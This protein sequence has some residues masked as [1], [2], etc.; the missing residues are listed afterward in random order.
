[1]FPGHGYR[2]G[3]HLVA[4]L[5]AV[6]RVLACAPVVAAY[7]HVLA[8]RVARERLRALAQSEG[9][10]APMLAEELVDRTARE[11]ASPLPS[12]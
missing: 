1:L 10:L 5:I 11:A 3:E 4:A 2:T 6:R 8:Q 12:R 9:R 7:V